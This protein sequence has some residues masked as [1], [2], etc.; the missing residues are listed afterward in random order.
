VLEQAPPPAKIAFV[1][2]KMSQ[3]SFIFEELFKVK[4]DL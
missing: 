2:T 4:N 1:K 3:L